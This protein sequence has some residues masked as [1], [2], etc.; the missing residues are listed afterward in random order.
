MK[1][2]IRV[3]IACG[4]G[5]ATSTVIADRVKTILVNEGFR[6]KIEQT[7]VV[8]VSKRARD[9]DLVVAS[10]QAP[11]GLTIPFISAV[12]YLT[13]L[14]QESTDRAILDAAHRISGEQTR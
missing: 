9:F 13:G 10:T 4:A 5:V 8:E 1:P 12:S 7:K 3:L 11:A 14:N 6:P 2:E